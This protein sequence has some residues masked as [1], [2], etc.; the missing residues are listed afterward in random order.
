MSAPTQALA[1]PVEG[2]VLAAAIK[3]LGI[4]HVLTVPDSHQK[5]VLDVLAKGTQ[6]R[7]LTICTE[8]EAVGMNM[9]LYAGG[10]KPML[11][12]QNN[13]LYAGIN[14]IK[15]LSFEARV[16]LLMMI[17]EFVRDPAVPSRE[18]RSRAVRMLEPVLETWGIPYFR[19]D[20]P[21][22]VGKLAQAHQQSL[23]NRGPVAVII[24][25]RT[26]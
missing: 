6:P 9:G 4:T 26:I 12:I 24:G 25:A 22:D 11:I 21:E 3:E 8:D 17:G 10:Q 14:A 15:A 5:T 7:L 23:D 18:N 1:R 19:I 13:G 16:P 2:A 20:G